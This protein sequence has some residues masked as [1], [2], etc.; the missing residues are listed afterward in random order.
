MYKY[1]L[2][3]GRYLLLDD[4]DIIAGMDE[5]AIA[6]DTESGTLLKHGSP[7]KVREWHRKSIQRYLD[8]GVEQLFS[9]VVVWIARFDIEDLNRCL[10][11]S[12]YIKVL[13]E[14]AAKKAKM[15]KPIPCPSCGKPMAQ[16]DGGDG[17][18][19]PDGCRV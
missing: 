11:I 10:L 9:T 4:S 12:G 17:L 5:V 6:Y 14:K 16:Q 13:A 1:R 7:D 19:C 15:T 18:Y 2:D 8:T 3:G